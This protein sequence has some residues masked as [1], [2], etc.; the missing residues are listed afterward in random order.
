MPAPA[1]GPTL[2]VRCS[3]AELGLRGSG[4]VGV[5]SS[6]GA[7]LRAPVVVLGCFCADKR[8]APPAA[9]PPSGGTTRTLAESQVGGVRVFF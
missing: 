9:A 6:A 3:G 5:G 2:R 7:R 4:A 1:E 8:G